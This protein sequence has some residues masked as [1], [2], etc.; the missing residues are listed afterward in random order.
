MA[1]TNFA[2]LTEHQ[3]KVW[4]TQLWRHMREH[5]FFAPFTSSGAN[6]VV[7]R[8]S[9]LTKTKKGNL[10]IMTLI[11]DL[12]GD[13]VAGDRYLEGNEESMRTAEQACRFDMLRH[14][15][16]SEGSMAD[17]KSIVNFRDA[18]INN[19]GYWLSDRINQLSFLTLSGVS[20]AYRNNGALRQGSDLPNLEFAA[21]VTPPSDRRRFRW[22]ATTKTLQYGGTTSDVTAADVP[23]WSLFVQ[24]K[25]VAQDEYMRGVGATGGQD[26]E[27]HAFL[28]PQAMAKLK[29]DDD[30]KAALRSAQSRGN[31]N[32]LFTG[33]AVKIDGITLH[34]HRYVFNTS[35][36]ASGSKWGSDGK[37]NGCQIL[38]CGAQALGLADIEE[39]SW[40]E[41]K[42][43][44]DNNLGISTGKMFGL[45]K[46]RFE[47][48]NASYTVQ[49]YGV[50]SIY[51][52]V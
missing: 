43:D 51:C 36:M 14:A 32:N 46:P 42:F 28:T 13:G 3:L 27:F 30:Y 15:V 18:S 9:D 23:M 29:E 44:Y 40:V 20:Y 4:R 24:L 39:P 48:R 5:L 19:L 50:M 17:Q 25:A 10:A 6:S 34:T 33:E 49:D 2:L 11:H 12:D 1:S 45:I 31:D 21:D 22:N 16:R 37:V 47:N 26:Q 52:A 35:G 41:K 38:F 8:I 7:T